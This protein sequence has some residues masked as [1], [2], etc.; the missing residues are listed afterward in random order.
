MHKCAIRA[1][2]LTERELSLAQQYKAFFGEKNV[3]VVLDQTS[4]TDSLQA[5]LDATQLQLEVFS[6]QTLASMGLNY[7]HPRI[8]WLCGDYSYYIMK[9]SCSWDYLWLV[10]PDLSITFDPLANFFNLFT[11]NP[12]D[13]IAFRLGLAPRAWYWH[14]KI[15][16]AYPDFSP[17]LCQFPITRISWEAAGVLYEERV[18]LSQRL[19]PQQAFP[20]DESFVATLC[21]GL[22]M[23][24]H[25]IELRLEEAF[26]N[27]STNEPIAISTWSDLSRLPANS[28]IHPVIP[29]DQYEQVIHRKLRACLDQSFPMKLVS[30]SI[31]YLPEKDQLAAKTHALRAIEKYLHSI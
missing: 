7:C 20:N 5:E 14:E 15:Q 3:H 27:F 13:F 21:S 1:H 24:C 2:K 8:G 17:F 18:K 29:I 23:K 19:L 26:T 30:K 11:V 25:P 12:A 16:D 4:I 9:A 22:G 31:K 6:G 28:V 10:E